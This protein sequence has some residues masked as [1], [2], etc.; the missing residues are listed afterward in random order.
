ML[1]HPNIVRLLEAYRDK[2]M[3]YLVMELCSG[4]FLDNCSIEYANVRA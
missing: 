4:P 2:K 3:F 1:R